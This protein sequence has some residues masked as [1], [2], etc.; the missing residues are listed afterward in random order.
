M[1]VTP[2]RTQISEGESVRL[3]FKVEGEEQFSLSGVDFSAPDFDIVNEHQESFIQS[4]YENGKFGVRHSQTVTK[5]L[6]P[7]RK[8]SLKIDNIQAKVNGKSFAASP[9]TIEVTGST[10]VSPGNQSGRS[11]KAPRGTVTGF[12]VR[13][14][15]DKSRAYKGEQII[16]SYYLYR[17]SRVFNIQVDKYPVLNGFLREDIDLPVMGTHLSSERVQLDGVT[18]D[19][20]LLARY[21][22]YPLKEGSLPIDSMAIQANYLRADS[23][24]GVD[25]DD[26]FAGF[27]QQMTPLRG[28]SRSD[29]IKVEVVA[30]PTDGRPADFS[31]GIGQFSLSASADKTSVR[32]GEA[33]TI[34]V[35]VEG[36]GNT[37]AIELAKP[38]LPPSVD[39][40]DSK[41]KAGPSRGGTSSKVFEFIV[42]PKQ[43]GRVEIPPFELSYFDPQKKQYASV[44]SGAISVVAEGAPLQASGK[45]SSGQ[46]DTQGNESD[47][48][49]KA[50]SAVRGS[51]QAADGQSSAW[52][53]KFLAAL[54]WLGIA[55]LI[56][57]AIGGL[58]YAARRGRIA[59]KL[60]REKKL[61]APDHLRSVALKKLHGLSQNSA[62]LSAQ[63][64]TEAYD[65][66]CGV[67]Y[68]ALDESFQ[69]GAKSLSRSELKRTLVQERSL[70]SEELWA[71]AA[72]ILEYAE[73]VRY[74]RSAGAVSE[75][76]ARHQLPQWLKATEEW[77]AALARRT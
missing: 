9:I 60:K 8:G 5:W 10:V 55:A 27:F 67:I 76:E 48:R 12:F 18:Y 29:D 72:K 2:D 42:I 36:R 61:S 25:E 13:V 63:E 65:G 33:I 50:K 58:A 47:S 44:K 39:L 70:L 15:T 77:L 43:P 6:R 30:L 71:R 11:G 53:D 38:Q 66:L 73:M 16:V 37:A 1:E 26:P 23:N 64:L 34:S 28:T 22:A 31:G 4:F 56:V 32:T 21:A 75:G 40:F 69:V 35:R 14:E 24:D 46:D 3:Q 20:S 68:E 19:R 17:R 49:S 52:L 74:A 45:P 59:L 62:R 51:D 41:G 7:M 54:K 57:A